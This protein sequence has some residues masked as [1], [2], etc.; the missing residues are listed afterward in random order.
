M[1][2]SVFQG[3]VLSVSVA[4]V[5]KEEYKKMGWLIESFLIPSSTSTHLQGRKVFE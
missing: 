2:Q 3:R 4:N 1:N 5:K